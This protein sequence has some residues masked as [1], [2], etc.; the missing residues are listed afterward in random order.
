MR[1]SPFSPRPS[2]STKPKET[3]D[4][5]D[6]LERGESFGYNALKIP[7][8]TPAP[9]PQIQA[10]SEPGEL[11]DTTAISG[12]VEPNLDREEDQNEEEKSETENQAITEGENFG[13]NALKIPTF[14]PAPPP[15]IQAKIEKW[16]P[17]LK[18][19]DEAQE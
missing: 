13:Y 1:T 10:K 11:T 19:L 3:L 17:R 5:Q 12:E 2:R 15:E 8:F 6:Q 9:A 14:T 18:I 16:I 7:T 4:V